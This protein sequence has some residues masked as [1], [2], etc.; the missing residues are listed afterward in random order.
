MTSFAH[1]S[2]ELARTYDLLSDSQFEGGKRLAE[3]L[4]LK[5]GD[6]VL[7][8][9]CGTGRLAAW[10]AGVVGPG[11]VVGID[12]LPDRVAV[13]RARAP[14]LRF[15]VGRAEDLGAFGNETFDVVCMS[16]VFHWVQDKPL[17]L[18]EARR[19]LRTG[20]RLGLTTMPRELHDSSTTAHVCASLVSRPPY[21]G[22]VDLASSAIANMGSTLTELVG[23][24][25]E[26]QFEILELHV[27]RRTQTFAS[28]DE[29][30]DFLQASSF[31]HFL[32]LV[33]EDLRL[34]FRTDIAAAFD[35]R[36]GPDGIST[37][38]H[39][40]ILVAIRS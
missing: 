28:G 5:A 34:S 38:M 2:A 36:R 26:A 20:G 15:E 24:L 39:R 29:V 1:D 3:R 10:M 8:V 7:D 21:R 32:L 4:A 33:P 11:D 31:G 14:G 6:R 35:A 30:V 25:V 19:V 16:A 9:G 18:A 27:V 23:L 12:P 40:T 37:Q 17:A 13:A 22:R